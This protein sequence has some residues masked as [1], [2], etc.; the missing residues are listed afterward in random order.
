MAVST[1]SALRRVAFETTSTFATAHP[2]R[3]FHYAFLGTMPQYTW[4]EGPAYVGLAIAQ[5]KMR[6]Q[7]ASFDA[8]AKRLGVSKGTVFRAAQR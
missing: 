2:R 5:V 3:D 1:L 6:S 4:A 8:I 7:G